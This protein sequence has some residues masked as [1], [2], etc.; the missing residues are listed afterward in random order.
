MAERPVFFPRFDAV[1]VSERYYE[2]EWFPGFA[3]SQKRKCVAS[4][5]DADFKWSVP[6]S[7]HKP[8]SW[9]VRMFGPDR[10]A[11]WTVGKDGVEPYD[12]PWIDPPDSDDD[13]FRGRV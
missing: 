12:G 10:T 13:P 1:G 2:F 7:P 3:P 8:R 6:I 4:L 11:F 5:H 9:L